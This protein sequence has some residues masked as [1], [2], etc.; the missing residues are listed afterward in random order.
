MRSQIRWE[1]CAFAAALA[2]S[3]CAATHPVS[4]NGSGSASPTAP[5]TAATPS[6]D[7]PKAIG[8]YNRVV[9]NG[10]THYC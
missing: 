9:R 6:N 8:D 5:A 10:Q 7:S 1:R 3:A 4:S 2:L